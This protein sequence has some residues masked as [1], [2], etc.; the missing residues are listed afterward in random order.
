MGWAGGGGGGGGG[1][2]TECSGGR[3]T[4]IMKLECTVF[5]RL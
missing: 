3:S 4:V 1:G 5:L 2:A